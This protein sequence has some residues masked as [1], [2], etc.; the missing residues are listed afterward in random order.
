MLLSSAAPKD[1]ISFENFLETR[2]TL[3]REGN[4]DATPDRPSCHVL[5][6][7]ITFANNVL[8]SSL[9]SRPTLIFKCGHLFVSVI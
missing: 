5:V 6:Y 1:C 9:H 7:V 3:Q 8:L 2:Q 4:D